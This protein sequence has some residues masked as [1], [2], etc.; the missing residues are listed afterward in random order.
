MEREDYAIEMMGYLD[1]ELDEEH[2]RRFEEKLAADPE[3]AAELARYRRL[4]E[5][6]GA[7]QFRE[8]SDLEWQHFWNRL[9]NRLERRAGW[10]FVIAGA[11]LVLAYGVKE[12]IM[13]PRIQPLLK[14]GALL[15]LVGFALLFWSVY[16]GKRRIWKVDRY[17]GVRR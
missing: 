3:L 15:M 11:A 1:G 17:R 10:I 12:L 7:M 9:Y 13:T 16:R 14:T 6:T 4:N 8:P 5:L 2:R